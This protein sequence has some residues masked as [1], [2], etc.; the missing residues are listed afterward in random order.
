MVQS[1][2]DLIAWQ[3]GMEFALH[4][5]RLTS[6]FPSNERYGLASQ[7]QRAAVSIPSNVSEGHQLRPKSYRHF[8]TLA[9]G[10]LA[11]ANTQIELACRLGYIDNRLFESTTTR[12]SE[13]RQVLHG[14][15][16]SIRVPN[17]ST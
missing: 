7:I 2:R 5:Y 3:L 8:L 15:R 1:Y 10:S 12:S 16:R 14:L 13:L 11:E 17:P 6:A 9:L 4:A